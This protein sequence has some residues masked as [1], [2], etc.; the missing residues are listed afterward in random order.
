MWSVTCYIYLIYSWLHQSSSQKRPVIYIYPSKNLEGT[1]H[2]ECTLLTFLFVD[3]SK[4]SND[5]ILASHD[6][7]HVSYRTIDL[8]LQ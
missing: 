2:L 5:A 1:E 6:K 8:A 4:F 3:K 7:K